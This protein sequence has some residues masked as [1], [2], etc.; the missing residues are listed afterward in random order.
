MKKLWAA[1]AVVNIVSFA[2]LGRVGVEIYRHKPPIPL[3]VVDE[4]FRP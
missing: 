3:Q 1:F 2:I 4:G